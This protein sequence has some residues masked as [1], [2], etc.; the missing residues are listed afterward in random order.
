MMY[1]DLK[2][3]IDNIKMPVYSLDLKKIPL[4]CLDCIEQTSLYFYD[5]MKNLFPKLYTSEKYFVKIS[6]L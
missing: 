1:D 2:L 6:N 3:L 4:V 5:G